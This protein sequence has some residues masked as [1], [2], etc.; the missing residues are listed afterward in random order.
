[1]IESEKLRSS[2]D[3]IAELAKKEFPS[4]NQNDFGEQ[5]TILS[6]TLKQII[7]DSAKMQIYKDDLERMMD[8]KHQV[9]LSYASTSPDLRLTWLVNLATFHEGLKNYEEQAHCLITIA[10][11][12]ASYLVHHKDAIKSHFE[13]K[14]NIIKEEST[15]SDEND[16]LLIFNNI[17]F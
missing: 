14:K 2:L 15:P 10:S 17:F 4:K 12:I 8:L 5:V 9:S 13:K 1:M 3:Y 6:Q 11:L 7:V 16:G